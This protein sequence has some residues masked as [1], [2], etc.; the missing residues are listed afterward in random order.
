MNEQ[1]PRM[2]NLRLSNE[3]TNKHARIHTYCITV[4]EYSFTL[5]Y[6]V[7]DD[8]QDDVKLIS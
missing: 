7:Q 5:R 2:G 8:V 1:N 3:R 4:V 6:D